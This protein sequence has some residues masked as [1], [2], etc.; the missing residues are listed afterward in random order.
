MKEAF[1]ECMTKSIKAILPTS[2]L[3]IETH[4][5][6]K[7]QQ[8]GFFYIRMEYK[9]HVVQIMSTRLFYYKWRLTRIHK[10]CYKVDWT[11][12]KPDGPTF[13]K[14]E[15]TPLR[16]AGEYAETVWTEN[17]RDQLTL[18]WR[19]S[20]DNNYPKNIKLLSNTMN[21]SPFQNDHLSI[22][23]PFCVFLGWPF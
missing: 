6:R 4:Q 10:M 7:W 1:D 12:R 14:Y 23:I 17:E 21:I 8:M 2:S 3:F 11:S 9:L 15:N 5:Y 22:M 19:P 20:V 13:G 18:S 16:G